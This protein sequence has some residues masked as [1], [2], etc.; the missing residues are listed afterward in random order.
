MGCDI[1][2]HIEIK[3]EGTWHHYSAPNV[4]RSYR[5]FAR[6]AGVRNTGGVKPIA[7]NRGLPEDMSLVTRL[8]WSYWELDGHSM[9]WMTGAEVES[10][11][12]DEENFCAYDEFGYLFGNG[13]TDKDGWP[14][15]VEACRMIFW[16]DN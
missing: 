1:H 7:P 10:L 6:M 2:C 8:A 12:N 15:G 14:P 4:D 9:S 5:L 11:T 13:F 16:F 3:V